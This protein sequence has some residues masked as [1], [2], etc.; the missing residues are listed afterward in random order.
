MTVSS[1]KGCSHFIELTDPGVGWGLNV[2]LGDFA[3]F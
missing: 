3:K 2:G 1:S